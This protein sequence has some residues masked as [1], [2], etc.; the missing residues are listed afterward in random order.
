MVHNSIVL[1]FE[2]TRSLS[3]GLQY[4]GTSSSLPLVACPTNYE[5]P[6]FPMRCASVDLTIPSF[7]T[8]P[9]CL[10]PWNSLPEEPECTILGPKDGQEPLLTAH[11]RQNLAS[12]AEVSIHMQEEP[13]V[14]QEVGGREERGWWTT[15]QGQIISPKAA[16]VQHR[17]PINLG[18]LHWNLVFQL[19]F[20]LRNSKSHVAGEERC[21]HGLL[22][23][24]RE[25]L[26][27]PHWGIFCDVLNSGVKGRA[28]GRNSWI[29]G[30]NERASSYTRKRKLV[31]SLWICQTFRRK[32]W[33][34]KKWG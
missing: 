28:Q 33:K 14:A 34:S 19:Q 12:R 23:N 1:R 13:L 20:H 2:Q 5:E 22:K 32:G 31:F 29:S 17:I 6:R 30:R 7:R 11:V 10:G 9:A 24:W 16:V 27:T 26:W 8:H 4:G 18:N 21:L 25:T 3:W 15:D